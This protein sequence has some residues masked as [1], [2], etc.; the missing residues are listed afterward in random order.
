MFCNQCN[1]VTISTRILLDGGTVCVETCR[2]DLIN[3]EMYSFYCKCE[4]T[5]YIKIDWLATGKT[6]KHLGLYYTGPLCAARVSI[7]RQLQGHPFC[8]PERSGPLVGEPRT[9]RTRTK[10]SVS[11]GGKLGREMADWILPPIRLTRN[12]K[13]SLTC[14]KSATRDPRLYFSSEGFEPANLGTRGQHAN[15]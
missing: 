13:G 4:F 8:S 15:H 10:P 6:R 12:R 14:R 3:K 9:A 11:E 2:R 7:F 1:N 5:A